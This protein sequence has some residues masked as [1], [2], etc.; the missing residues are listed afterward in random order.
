MPY[1]FVLPLLL[2]GFTSPYAGASLSWDSEA[3]SPQ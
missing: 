3:Q 1:R 2:L